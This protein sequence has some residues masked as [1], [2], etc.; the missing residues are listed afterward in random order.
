[1][2]TGIIEAQGRVELFKRQKKGALLAVSKPKDYRTIPLG[3]SIA[4]NGVCLTVVRQDAKQLFFQTVA[5]TLRRSNLGD[6]KTGQ[7]VNLERALSAKSRIEGHFVLGHVDG[8]GVIREIRKQGM[9][10]DFRIE[11]P[12]SIGPFVLEKGS[13]AIDGVSLT[14][15]KVDARSFWVYAI[16]HTLKVTEMGAFKKGQK[17]NLEADILLKFLHRLMIS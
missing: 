15:G 7:Y 10:R 1:M 16:P 4:V 6:L 17:V 9:G 8:M 14:V 13:I 12:K 3:S 11:I 2:F 5:E